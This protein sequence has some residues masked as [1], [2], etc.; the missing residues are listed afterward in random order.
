MRYRLTRSS[1]DKVLAGVCGGVA[2]YYGWD[3][4]KVRM[5]FVLIGIITAVLPMS[6]IYLVL[7]FVIPEK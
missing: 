2:E 1:Y 4:G 6:L 5:A 7:G 3:S